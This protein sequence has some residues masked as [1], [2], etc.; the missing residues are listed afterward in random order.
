MRFVLDCS[1]AMA[2]CFEDE[3]AGYADAVL[4]A[5]EGAEALVPGLWS[6]EVAN[7]LLVAERRGRI[8]E[9]A[10]AR[11]V[12][13][14]RGLPI[15]IDGEDAGRALGNV[16]SLAR[17]RSLSSYDAAYL[18]LAMREGLPLATLDQR[19]RESALR[20]GV[21]VFQAK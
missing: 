19:L 13:L 12:E 18:D 7:V 3:S 15:S 20:S 5:L 21:Q 8:S 9:A 14:L 2:W 1:V 6:L 10:A 16:L 17:E 11:F 4:G